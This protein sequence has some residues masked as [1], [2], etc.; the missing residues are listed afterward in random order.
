MFAMLKKPLRLP[1]PAEDRSRWRELC[2]G[3][4]GK[5]GGSNTWIEACV[6]ALPA[7]FELARTVASFVP[8]GLPT[9]PLPAGESEL[10]GGGGDGM[11]SEKSS[12]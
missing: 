6:E 12:H 2:A 11:A 10:Y 3:G 5:R 8:D 4:G 7:G 1:S 9:G